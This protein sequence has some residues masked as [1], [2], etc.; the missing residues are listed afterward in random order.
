MPRM[1]LMPRLPFSD[2]RAQVDRITLRRA[3][4]AVASTRAMLGQM[5]SCYNVGLSPL[6]VAEDIIHG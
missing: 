6:E 2:W 1:E 3:G 5:Q 4:F